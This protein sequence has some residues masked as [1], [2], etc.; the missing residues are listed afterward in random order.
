MMLVYKTYSIAS[1]FIEF[2]LYYEESIAGELTPFEILN[3][4]E[5]NYGYDNENNVDIAIY[6]S[7]I[8]FTIDD[9]NGDNFSILS[10]IM[11]SYSATYP[12]NFGEVLTLEILVNGS[13]M[14][15]GIL[16]ELESDSDNFELSLKF[17]D[18]VNKLK[19]INIGNPYVLNWLHRNGLLTRKTLTSGLT[20]Y[21]YSY[22]FKT[23]NPYSDG[24]GVKNLHQA[25]INSPIENVII[26]L[27]RLLDPYTEVD[28]DN[29][30]KFGDLS[31]PLGSYVNIDEVKVRRLFSNLLGR[32]VVLS[33]SASYPTEIVNNKPGVIVGDPGIP[34]YNYNKPERFE[35]V[36]EDADW[37][38]YYHNWDGN[39]DDYV[40]LKFE[41]GLDE[42]TVSSLLKTLA[43]NLFSY[44]GYK[45]NGN[46]YWKHRRFNSA[47]VQ[48]SSDNILSMTKMLTVDRTEGVKIVDYYESTQYGMDGTDFGGDNSGLLTYRIPLNTY[49]TQN[50]YE[51]R[52]TY[53]S[54]DKQVIYFYDTEIGYNDLPMEV[55]SRAEYLQFQAFRDKYE[56]VLDGIDYSFHDT[57]RLNYRNYSGTFRPV[58][59]AIDLVN[60]QTTLTGLEIG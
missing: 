57:Y 3:I 36:Y 34:D 35:T 54:T 5:L 23:I 60:N 12:F 37:K 38:V 22:G 4:G 10:D 52:M 42:R 14:F 31:E 46:V 27:F 32:Y 47:P 17:V 55:I 7:N 48:V 39:P 2:K 20:P 41:K 24:Y 26:M 6:P 44:Y 28:F 29:S 25:D 11:S 15:K 1:G 45:T 16:D 49:Q 43:R 33:K 40:Q 59:M 13:R 50:G 56:I 21:A 58:T 53:G 30:Y 8:S 51:Y 19:D 18:G 9:F